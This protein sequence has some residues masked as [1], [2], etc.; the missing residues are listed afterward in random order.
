MSVV[1]ADIGYLS[2]QRRAGSVAGYE[3]V[4]D[5]IRV[6]L[7]DVLLATSPPI[8]QMVSAWLVAATKHGLLIPETRDL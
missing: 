1:A 5:D 8:F 6:F 4:A 7:V 2:G 3:E